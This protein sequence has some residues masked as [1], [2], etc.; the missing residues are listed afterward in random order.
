PKA[1][2]TSAKPKPEAKPKPPYT[3]AKGKSITTRRGILD[4][5]AEV[6]PDDFRAGQQRL[7]ALVKRGVVV[8]T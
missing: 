6:R 5:G 7:D 4:E 3:V 8:K 1:A 2:E